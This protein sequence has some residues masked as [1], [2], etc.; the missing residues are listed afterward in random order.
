MT[1]R[2]ISPDPMAMGD[3]FMGGMMGLE[4]VEPDWAHKKAEGETV[5]PPIDVAVVRSAIIDNLAQIYDPEIPVDIWELGLVYTL[6]VAESGDVKVVMT[7]TAP[8]C[9]VAG[10]M[11]PMVEKGVMQVPGV[12]TCDVELTWDPPWSLDKASEDA[13]MALGF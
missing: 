11:P 9:P 6:D 5:T 8:G 4:V 2:P 10:S 13:R 1:D 12:A 7:L 3:P